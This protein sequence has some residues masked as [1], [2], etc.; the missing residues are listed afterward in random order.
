MRRSLALNGAL[1][2]VTLV[3]AGCGLQPLYG[4]G[5]GSVAARGLSQIEVG[6]IAGEAGWL[7]ANSLRDRLGAGGTAASPRYRLDVRLDD[8][9]EGLGLR[10]DDSIGRERRT[11]RARYQLVDLASDEIVIDA[12][13]G[14]DAGIDVVSSEYAVIA[15]ERTAL[16]RLS[17]EVADQIVTRVALTL[18]EGR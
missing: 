5:A 15:A 9:L 18:R 6:P 17:T 11:L 7:V 1:L 8:Q 12:T 14:S 16:E 4:G 13:A 2:P 10:G 3:L